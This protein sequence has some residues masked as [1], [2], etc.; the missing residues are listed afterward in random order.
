MYFI[1]TVLLLGK[2]YTTHLFQLNQIFVE[3]TDTKLNLLFLGKQ[4]AWSYQAASRVRKNF[5][6]PHQGRTAAC[7]LWSMVIWSSEMDLF[8]CLMGK[9]LLHLILIFFFYRYI[10]IY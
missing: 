7:V 4:M 6:G 1:V 10:Q 9:C 3:H 5:M 2:T 8:T